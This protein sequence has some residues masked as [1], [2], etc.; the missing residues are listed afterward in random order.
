MYCYH[1]PSKDLPRINTHIPHLAVLFLAHES[2]QPLLTAFPA[3]TVQTFRFVEVLRILE[4]AHI[5]LLSNAIA[6][7][8][9]LE[10]HSWSLHPRSVTTSKK[11]HRTR[12]RQLRPGSA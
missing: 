5:F 10:F 12:K 6:K 2:R 4:I 8:A 3:T 11:G 7:T 9:R 1:Y